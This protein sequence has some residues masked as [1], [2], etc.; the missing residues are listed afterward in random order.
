LFKFALLA[1]VCAATLFAQTHPA[2][3]APERTGT[4]EPQKPAATPA[5]KTTVDFDVNNMDRTADPCNDFY[6]YACGSWLKNNPIPPDQSRWGRFTELEERN[7][8]VLREILEE[9]AKPEPKRDSVAQK[10]GDFYGA[11]MDVKAIDAKGV[12]PLEPEFTRIRN[13]KDKAEIAGEIAR[14]HRDGTS[15]AFQFSS[16]QDAK[17]SNSVIAQFDQGGL[18][19]PDRDYYLKDDPKSVELRYKYTA[20][21]ARMLE[22]AGEKPAVAKRNAEAVMKLETALAK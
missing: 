13:L 3:Q 18:G 15:A 19:L 21:V 8:E 22:L 14:L 17:D 1:L 7:R 20:H 11:C 12:A 16:G 4:A 2:G 10:I 9:A 5:K 6:Q